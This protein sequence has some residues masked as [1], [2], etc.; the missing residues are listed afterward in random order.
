[1]ALPS[2]FDYVRFNRISSTTEY[3]TQIL[4]S[5]NTISFSS[6]LQFMLS[7]TPNGWI[8]NRTLRLYGYTT[9]NQ[10]T[11]TAGNCSFDGGTGS[12]FKQGFLKANGTQIEF[13]EEYARE[14]F[15]NDYYGMGIKDSNYIVGTNSLGTFPELYE[16]RDASTISTVNV[17]GANPA[18]TFTGS[19]TVHS[20][21]YMYW[22]YPRFKHLGIHAEY[23]WFPL[24]LFNTFEIYWNT[25]AS[26]ECYKTTSTTNA[27]LSFSQF[28]LMYDLLK[29]SGDFAE[30][31]NRRYLPNG[32]ST[33]I[34]HT[35]QYSVIRNAVSLLT[36]DTS[37]QTRIP[38]AHL[39]VR[40]LRTFL[41]INSALSATNSTCVYLN[42]IKYLQVFLNGTQ[43]PQAIL[44]EDA[45]PGL[46]FERTFYYEKGLVRTNNL[47]P[48]P[49]VIAG[50]GASTTTTGFNAKVN[51]TATYAQ[52]AISPLHVITISF[53]D[54]NISDIVSQNGG[55]GGQ[56]GGITLTGN[57]ITMNV[58]YFPATNAG[59][60]TQ[61]T[62]L[63]YD[64]WTYVGGNSILR[65]Q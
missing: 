49:W 7:N 17:N 34:F 37:V 44:D 52:S 24:F 40:K 8:N 57:N 14:T 20:D 6:N 5:S 31:I 11:V 55:L 9:F 35:L 47:A 36:T 64:S 41:A 30:A 43:V 25:A 60:F 4:P 63:Y 28:Q 48:Q 1:M 59:S 51:G 62:Y 19:T 58:T 65:V 18:V 26:S 22:H 39:S 27:S 46:M 13:D 45:Y 53:E 61:T 42:G 23:D 50:T 21:K 10:L 32:R 38:D 33:C 2:G 15:I 16:G 54:P 29:P 3:I 56:S 12:L